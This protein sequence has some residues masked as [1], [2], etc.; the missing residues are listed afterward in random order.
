MRRVPV[1]SLSFSFVLSLLLTVLTVLV[2]VSGMPGQAAAADITL[3]WD[4]SGESGVA[5]YRVYYKRGDV[6]APYN[7]TGA[8][9]GDSPVTIALAD[10]ADASHPSYTLTGVED[11]VFYCLAVTAYTAAGA[12]S[13]YSNEVSLTTSVMI[14]NQM[15][16]AN[17]GP[18]QSVSKGAVVHLE[19]GNSS[20]PE[21]DLASYR[22]VQ[23]SGPTVVLDNADSAR[24]SFT[25][26]EVG[27]DGATLSFVLE[28][29]DGGGLSDTDSCT[30]NVVWY[31]Q[32]PVA[33]AGLDQM[34]Q[35]ETLVV[36]AGLCSTDP[37]DAIA[38]YH[39][40]QT[41]GPA[42]VL[43]G[44]ETAQP[45]FI[46]PV[47]DAAG[48]S[49]TF[50]LTVEDSYGLSASDTCMVNVSWFNAAP[51]AEAGP[52]QTAV[53]K[54]TVVLDA[55]GS[56]DPD[57]GI[58]SYAWRQ[59]SGKAV[60]LSD[61]ASA[62]PSFTM[63]ASAA[64]GD[65]LAFELVVTDARGLAASDSCQ[66]LAATAVHVEKS[67]EEKSKDTKD[68][69]APKN[70][71]ATGT[72]SDGDSA[73]TWPAAKETASEEGSD[74]TETAPATE[75][76]DV[77]QETQET[78]T[79]SVDAEAA[80]EPVVGNNI[81]SAPQN[82]VVRAC[83]QDGAVAVIITAGVFDDVDAGDR[84]LKTQWQV[85]RRSDGGLVLNHTGVQHLRELPLPGLLLEANTAYFCRAR[86]WDSRGGASEWSVPVHF[87]TGA[88]SNDMNE[89]GVPDDQEPAADVDLNADG[90]ADREQAIVRSVL[91]PVSGRAIG[92]GIEHSDTVLAVLSMAAVDPATACGAQDAAEVREQ[93]PYGLINFRL[94]VAAP[95]DTATVTVYLD[96]PADE[97]ASW[98]KYNPIDGSWQDYSAHAVFS[99]DRKRVTLTLKDGGFGDDDGIA[100]GV[101]VDPSGIE[102]LPEQTASSQS[103]SG[104]TAAAAGGGGG[105]G[106]CFIAGSLGNAG[107]SGSWVTPCLLVLFALLGVGMSR[108]KE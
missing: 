44:A 55:T 53:P 54:S 6:G 97:S 46:A 105:G 59:T 73:A 56:R 22:W 25:A 90:I 7:G 102:I 84:H 58:A 34:V 48:I 66:V 106:G 91:S 17:A 31:N 104:E 42:V 8:A 4:A 5:G 43:D 36:L 76:G 96:A 99:A 57:G 51:I 24:A 19:G 10:L 60:V 3:A 72:N 18:D 108:R 35:E 69:G 92:L 80:G 87:Q 70:S 50:E 23:Q 95:G 2:T 78:S 38:A 39:W 27:V 20:D 71:G 100:N 88:F 9:E 89:D 62:T 107:A 47:T 32:P 29:T 45:S 21:Y 83:A 64:A 86:F 67:T 77:A 14:Q 13:A 37:D 93:Y 1:L 81:P 11:G 33:C 94:E 101:I 65:R 98:V 74:G 79:G 75:T 49:L 12:E 61:G 26:P 40:R 30:V 85:G 16:L 68:S 103:V 28:V 41:G 82:M 15:P 63:P 52:D